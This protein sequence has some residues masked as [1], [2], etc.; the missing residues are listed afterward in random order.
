MA[1][2]RITAI[3]IFCSVEGYTIDLIWIQGKKSF[4]LI[5]TLTGILLS[6]D[7]NLYEQTNVKSQK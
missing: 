3:K 4:G 5:K 1:W 7:M 2:T 6:N